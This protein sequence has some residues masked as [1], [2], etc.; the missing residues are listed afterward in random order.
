MI[1]AYIVESMSA[2]TVWK[3]TQSAR[4]AYLNKLGVTVTV[5]I[6]R[7]DA[8][9]LVGIVYVPEGTPFAF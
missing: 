8:F 9:T 2:C 5:D 3:G 6:F 4:R 1:V 7:K